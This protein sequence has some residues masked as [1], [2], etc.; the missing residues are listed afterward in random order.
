MLK[1][2]DELIPAPPIA[3][4]EVSP[5]NSNSWTPSTEL[6]PKADRISRV[7]ITN[8]GVLMTSSDSDGDDPVADPVLPYRAPCADDHADDGADHRAD[9]QQPQADPDAPP[10]FVSHRLAGDGGAEI[11]ADHA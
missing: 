9:D 8:T 10:Q 6:A 7:A 5:V 11:A 4:G 3:S 2:V 1:T